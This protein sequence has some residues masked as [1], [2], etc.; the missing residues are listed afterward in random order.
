MSQPRVTGSQRVDGVLL[1]GG[2]G[3]DLRLDEGADGSGR[4]RVE[5]PGDDIVGEN[6]DVVLES[7]NESGVVALHGLDDFCA[8]HGSSEGAESVRM[9]IFPSLPKCEGAL[10]PSLERP[11]GEP[12]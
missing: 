4:R 1:G 2:V 9:P 3:E 5:A 6:V 12:G 11:T 8:I 7:L 10:N